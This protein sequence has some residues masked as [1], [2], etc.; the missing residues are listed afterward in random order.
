M[1]QGPRPGEIAQ[2]NV[3]RAWKTLNAVLADE[4]AFVNSFASLV[5][6]PR[7]P[8]RVVP[9]ARELASEELASGKLVKSPSSRFA[10]IETES[11]ATLCLFV[12]G[13]RFEQPGNNLQAVIPLCDVTIDNVLEITTAADLKS[14]QSLLFE[15]V[16]QGS[17]IADPDWSVSDYALRLCFTHP[18]SS[19]SG[20]LQPE[21]VPSDLHRYAPPETVG[22]PEL[23]CQAL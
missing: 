14:W 15:L 21:T 22:I 11:P 3:M 9:I 17:L 10:W 8:E 6:Q 2:A 23:Y 12:N 7:Y 1:Q 4:S 16:C 20:R 5:T 18:V 13:D 19:N